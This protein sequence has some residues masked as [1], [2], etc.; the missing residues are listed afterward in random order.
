[1]GRWQHDTVNGRSLYHHP[2]DMTDHVAVGVAI[3]R[4]FAAL[5]FA[6]LVTGLRPTDVLNRWLEFCVAYHQFDVA[7]VS[8]YG[9]A[10]KKRL[11]ASCPLCRDTV[12]IDAIIENA[13]AIQKM[14]TERCGSFLQLLWSLHTSDASTPNHFLESERILPHSASSPPMH[15][16]T[17]INFAAHQS[18]LAIIADGLVPTR[19]IRRGLKLALSGRKFRRMGDDACLLFA[20]LIGLVNH[21]RRECWCWEQCEDEFDAVMRIRKAMAMRV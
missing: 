10:D 21:H 12:K 2:A 8:Q 16:D 17:E 9:E 14:E 15:S 19:A 7:V 6:V 20:Q 13:K 1:M 3:N 5:A 18:A 11:K 4:I